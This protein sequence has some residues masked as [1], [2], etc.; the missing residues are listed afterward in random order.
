MKS[1]PIRL[2]GQSIKVVDHEGLT[3]T[4]CIG[5]A[6]TSIDDLSLALVNVQGPTSE[7]WLTIHY[8]EYMH[9][10]EGCLELHYE[11]DN[12]SLNTVFIA[13][14]TR[15]QPRFPAGITKYIPVCLPAFQPERCIREEGTEASNVSKKLK[16]LH[17]KL[18]A[19]EVNEKYNRVDTIYH[20]C[21]KKAWEDCKSQRKAYFPPT[22]VADGK[23]THATSVPGRLISTAN[24]FYTDSVGDWI[25]LELNRG[26]LEQ[27]GIVTVFEAAMPVGEKAADGKWEDFVFPHIYGGIPTHLEGI[28]TNIYEMVRSND[29]TF[30]SI[31]D[32]TG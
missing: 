11:L 9:V 18:T 5:N 14:G 26:G 2:I 1:S 4:E 15:F 12:K 7:P 16:E 8:D 27:L 21:Q 31:K 30:L 10:T 25:C 28:V 3:I 13:K 6:S 17:S 29:G 20:M 22:F 23:M 19:A 24:H 32:L